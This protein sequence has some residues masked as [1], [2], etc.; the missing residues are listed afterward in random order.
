M[1]DEERVIGERLRS[2]SLDPRNVRLCA[3]LGHAPAAVAL[4]SP[5]TLRVKDFK[6]LASEVVNAGP[7]AV[8]QAAL[9]AARIVPTSE[10]HGDV[11]EQLVRL[12]EDMICSERSDPNML[13][14]RIRL[15]SPE[16]AAISSALMLIHDAI[17]GQTPLKG[18]ESSLRGLVFVI[19]VTS[20]WVTLERYIECLCQ[21]FAR[22]LLK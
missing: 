5:Q 8:A 9:C 11:Q 16:L 7:L 6:E 13:L 4:G 15:S 19:T 21:H 2:G 18:I 10:V 14:R 1:T 3:R 22:E 17:R 12:A 20:P